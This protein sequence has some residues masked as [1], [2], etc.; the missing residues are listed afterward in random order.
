MSET[1]PEADRIAAIR[2]RLAEVENELFSRN[3]YAPSGILSRF[4]SQA[5]LAREQHF[6]ALRTE[7]AELLS[8][9]PVTGERAG[10]LVMTNHLFR[11]GNLVVRES[12]PEPPRD[13]GY[14]PSDPYQGYAREMNWRID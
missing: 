7:R 4:N 5:Q 8:R 2:A 13:D 14:D 12:E 6:A 3:A 10:H 1:T 11:S 9:L